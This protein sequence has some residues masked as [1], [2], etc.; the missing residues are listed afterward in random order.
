MSELETACWT[1]YC[2]VVSF[3]AVQAGVVAVEYE[4]LKLKGIARRL[5][6]KAYRMIAKTI[7]EIA[8][9]EMRK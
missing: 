8:A 9:K 2:D 5:F 4:K 7:D 6:L 1:W 3:S